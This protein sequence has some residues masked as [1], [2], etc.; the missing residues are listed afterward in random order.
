MAV[1][2]PF[3]Q[4]SARR[5][6][7]LIEVLIVV[8]LV[9]ILLGVAIPSVGRQVTNDRVQ[10]SAMLVQGLLEE[11]SLQAARRRAPVRVGISGSFI[12]VTDRAS[13]TVLKQRSFGAASPDLKATVQMTP[14]GGVTIFPNGRSDA[15]VTFQLSGGDASVRVVRTTTGILRR[16]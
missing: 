12:Q 13:G 5:G 6:F 2:R 14:S 4:S 15:A 1:F 16:Q 7:T 11:A 9:G 8:T 10:R 3:P